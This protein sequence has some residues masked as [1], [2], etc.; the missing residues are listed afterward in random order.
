MW[1]LEFV[2]KIYNWARKRFRKPELRVFVYMRHGSRLL[3]EDRD[4]WLASDRYKENPF[5][6]PLTDLGRSE[7]LETIRQLLDVSD[8]NKLDYIYA[9]PYSRTMETA[10]IVSDF[11]ATMGKRLLIRIE[12]GLRENLNLYGNKGKDMDEALSP[13]SAAELYSI[14]QNYRPYIS[15]EQSCL[16]RSKECAHLC[17]RRSVNYILS[18]SKNPFVIAHGGEV[19]VTVHQCLT[20]TNAPEWD[21]SGS[22]SFNFVAIYYKTDRWRICLTPTR[23]VDGP[24][25]ESSLKG[26]G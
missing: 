17:L 11:T 14:D 4:A 10:Q 16:P 8:L 6:D 5:D 2:K 15:Y 22:T 18:K 21:V 19:F 1:L 7:T 23:L 24:P 26:R 3:A 13:Q 25:A 20:N 12:Y 9:S